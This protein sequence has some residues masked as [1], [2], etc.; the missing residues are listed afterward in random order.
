MIKSTG[1]GPIVAREL[2]RTAGPVAAPGKSAPGADPVDSAQIGAP[3]RPTFAEAARLGLMPAGAIGKHTVETDE[4]LKAP[5]KPFDPENP[6]SL[7]NDEPKPFTQAM[8]DYKLVLAHLCPK[9]DPLSAAAALRAVHTV[10]VPALGWEASRQSFVFLQRGAAHHAFGDHTRDEAV[11][12]FLQ[13]F[14]VSR[15]LESACRAVLALGRNEAKIST[16]EQTGD[17]IVGGIRIPRRKA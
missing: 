4:T 11:E 8:A 15:D 14:V 1:I 9:D 5:E 17:V 2:A 7:L 3:P 16:D 10:L 6:A 13:N 12:T